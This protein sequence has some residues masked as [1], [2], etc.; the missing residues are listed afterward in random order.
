LRQLTIRAF[1]TAILVRL[2]KYIIVYSLKDRERLEVWM[3]LAV[4]IVRSNEEAVA[5]I[6]S[7]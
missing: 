1:P 6:G 4:A 2:E 5:I 3:Y 7:N